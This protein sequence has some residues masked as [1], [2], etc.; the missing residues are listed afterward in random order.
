LIAQSKFNAFK[1]DA[2]DRDIKLFLYLLVITN[3]PFN[4]GLEFGEIH[5]LSI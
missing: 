3:L 2:I 4:K 1:I 5:L